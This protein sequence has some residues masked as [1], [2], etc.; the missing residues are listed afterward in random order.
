MLLSILASKQGHR[1]RSDDFVLMTND[2]K[3]AYF[4]APT[5]R[6]IY[7]KIPDED[8]EE[9]D[10]ERVGKLNLSLCGT[11]D[12]AMN[13]TKTY[14]DYM[15]SLGFVVGL[16][17]PCNFYHPTRDISC[18]VHGGDFTSV[19]RESELRWL[20]A[21]L[22]AKF[23]IKTDVLGPEDGHKK[24]VRVL[25]RILRWGAEGIEYEPDQRHAEQVIEALGLIEGKGVT[26]PGSRDDVSKAESENNS[27][28]DLSGDSRGG[29]ALLNHALPSKAEFDG[30]VELGEQDS[31]KELPSAEA[32]RYRAVSARLNY[33]CQD[34]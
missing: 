20:D 10:E 13:W 7:I 26:T 16:S 8:W 32:T 3:R 15:R 30:S 31:S 9:G 21:R 34:R 22:Q 24:E 2:V 12:A 1:R 5:T 29:S 25:N 17:N 27:C 19:G 6:P 14:T 28:Q 4:Y 23:E 18:T 33:L 11:R